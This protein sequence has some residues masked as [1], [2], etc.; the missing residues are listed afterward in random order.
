MCFD[1]NH[2]STTHNMSATITAIQPIIPFLSTPSQC[3][4][5]RNDHP[6]SSVH[7][8]LISP[9][10]LLSCLLL[11]PYLIQRFLPIC[12]VSVL[13]PIPFLDPP[14]FCPL[15]SFSYLF[16][17]CPH[18]HTHPSPIFSLFPPPSNFI[19]SFHFPY[20]TV[21]PSSCHSPFYPSPPIL[22]ALLPSTLFPVL[23]SFLIISPSPVLHSPHSLPLHPG[24]SYLS[25]VLLFLPTFSS[26]LPS[27]H[28]LLFI[29]SLFSPHTNLLPCP[30][31]ET[32]LCAA[33]PP[34][35]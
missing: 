12:L 23:S 15:F 16:F 29:S 32:L 20:S 17:P 2:F 30:S 1:L 3:P 26:L 6:I 5:I 28:P 27:L 21:L 10:F 14:F 25:V 7:T 8:I 18:S 19:D 4:E 34:A 22:S 24:L 33:P 31:G 11:S 13:L 35:D 9:S